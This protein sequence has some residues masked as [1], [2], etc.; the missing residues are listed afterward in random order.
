LHAQQGFQQIY[1]SGM[2]Y[3]N[4]LLFK[5]I[6]HSTYM[7]SDYLTDTCTLIYQMMIQNSLISGP[8]LH[9]KQGF[10]NKFVI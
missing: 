4:T 5:C 6:V 10:L 9:A 2:L 8:I 1:N 7:M 3:V